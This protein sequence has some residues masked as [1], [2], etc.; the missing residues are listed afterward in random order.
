MTEDS[1]LNYSNHSHT[2]VFYKYRVNLDRRM[3]YEMLYVA[4]KSDMPSYVIT[5][6]FYHAS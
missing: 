4:D 5:T 2:S 3:L 6:K 1:L